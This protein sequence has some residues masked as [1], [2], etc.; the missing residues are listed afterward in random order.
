MDNRSNHARFAGTQTQA[1]TEQAAETALQ[2][3]ESL[4]AVSPGAAD[5]VA[6]SAAAYFDGI[7]KLALASQAILLKQKT[8]DL[9]AMDLQQA[10]EDALGTLAT[11]IFAGAA[12][13]VAAAAAA[14]E[15]ESAGFAID[16]IDRSIARYSALLRKSEG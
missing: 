11:D 13:A 4:R 3:L 7:A 9:A 14:Q 5:L 8:E 15:A 12:A 10:A 1:K 2:A 6:Q 16:Q